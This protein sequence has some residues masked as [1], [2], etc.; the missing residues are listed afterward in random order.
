MTSKTLLY[1]IVQNHAHAKGVS[2]FTDYITLMLINMT[3]GLVILALFIWKGLGENEID[4]KWASGFA[5][6]GLLA[7]ITG[8]HMTLTWPLPGPFNMA[9]GELSV[10]LGSIYLITAWCLVKRRSLTPITVYAFFAGIAA[11]VVGIRIIGLGL[12][13][14]PALSGIGFILTG[15]GGVFAYAVLKL[16]K[17]RAIRITGTAVVLIAA[18]IWAFIGYGAYWMHM[19]SLAK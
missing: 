4:A 8:L 10:F 5:A 12:T 9:Y 13:Q 7:F 2:M 17:S 11:I 1:L 16:K 15:S 14:M 6:S 18:I 3:A 19:E